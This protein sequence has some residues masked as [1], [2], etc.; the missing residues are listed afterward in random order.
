MKVL[1]GMAFRQTTG[2]VESLLRLI[3][4]N[5]AVPGF[6]TL[7]RRPRTLAVNIPYRGAHDPLHV[8]ID[9]T[10][11]KVKGEEEWSVR[12]HDGSKRRV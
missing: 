4:V 5:W 1:F 2:F 6:S 9:C 10:G 11:I 8:L 7:S 3:S 12:R